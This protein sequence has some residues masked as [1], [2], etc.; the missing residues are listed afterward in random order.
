[1]PE[2]HRALC[3]VDCEGKPHAGTCHGCHNTVTMTYHAIRN[4]EATADYADYWLCGD[5]RGRGMY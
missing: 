4:N 1:M 2:T 3:T 5:C